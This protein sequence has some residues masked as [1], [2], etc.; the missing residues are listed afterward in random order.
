MY[1]NQSYQY[2]SNI[3]RIFTFFSKRQEEN[4]K[5]KRGIKWKKY[6][7]E[8]RNTENVFINMENGITDIITDF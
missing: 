7:K 1:I 3:W 8:R 6:R 4:I 5:Q 2:I